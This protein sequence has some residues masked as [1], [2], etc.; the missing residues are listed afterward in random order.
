MYFYFC[1]KKKKFFKQKLKNKQKQDQ[2]ALQF[3][4]VSN[5]Q[6]VATDIIVKIYQYIEFLLEI[7]SNSWLSTIG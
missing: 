1:S 7:L 5:A 6:E 2:T 3:P 4:L